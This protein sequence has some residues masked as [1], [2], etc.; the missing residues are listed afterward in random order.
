MKKTN[1]LV[2]AFAV[3][4]TGCSAIAADEKRPGGGMMS[5]GTMSRGMMGNMM[6]ENM[7]MGNMMKKTDTNGDGLLSKDEF[8]K[9]HEAMFD[10]LKNKD[11]V[12]DLKA[13]QMSCGDMMGDGMMSDDHNM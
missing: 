3:V 13:M 8:M 9:S 2:I 12:V 10:K 4:T 6:M 7:M 5:K 1:L 11:G